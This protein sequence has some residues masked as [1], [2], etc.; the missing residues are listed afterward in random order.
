MSGTMLHIKGNYD[1][2]AG[3]FDS[4][5]VSKNSIR[6]SDLHFITLYGAPG[7][8]GH[9]DKPIHTEEWKANSEIEIVNIPLATRHKVC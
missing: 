2:P 9:S 1:L 6:V 7:R 4:R 5:L 8:N 3:F